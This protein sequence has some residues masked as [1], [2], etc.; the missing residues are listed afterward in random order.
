MPRR[1]NSKASRAIRA[2]VYKENRVRE[3]EGNA[4]HLQ[5][6][7]KQAAPVITPERLAADI[8]LGMEILR[9]VQ[10]MRRIILQHLLPPL[11]VLVQQDE[12]IARNA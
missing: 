8:Q 4:H 7:A 3:Q 9:A 6:V 1:R 10:A 2:A 12:A 5:Q 11:G